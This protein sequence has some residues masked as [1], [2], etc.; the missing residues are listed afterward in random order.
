[1]KFTALLIQPEK[2]MG[3]S[4]GALAGARKIHANQN[5]SKKPL[6]GHRHGHVWEVM[7]VYFFLYFSN[8][9]GISATIARPSKVSLISVLNSA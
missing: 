6:I 2:L 3:N 8:I 7:Q 1:M 9:T 4:M 5:G